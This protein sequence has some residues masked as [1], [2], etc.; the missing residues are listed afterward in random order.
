MGRKVTRGERGEDVPGVARTGELWI[1][2]HAGRRR[3]ALN[4]NILS[5]LKF[6]TLFNDSTQEV[7]T[8]NKL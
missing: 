4:G 2:W 8:Y 1:R 5:F 7:L 3:T 6:S